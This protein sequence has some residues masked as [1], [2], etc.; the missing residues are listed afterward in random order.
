VSKKE[1]AIDWEKCKGLLLEGTRSA[2]TDFM[3]KTPRSELCAIGY[4]FELGNESPQFDLCADTWSNRKRSPD[5]ELPDARW[6][7]GNYEFP[8]GLSSYSELGSE[9]N[10]VAGLLH[11]TAE[12]E[13]YFDAVYKG[14]VRIG[15]EVLVELARGGFLGDWQLLDFNVSEVGD[16]IEVVSARNAKIKKLIESD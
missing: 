5:W 11:N 13:R 9:W 16:S 12:K 10:D 6:N 8:A 3:K 2:I 7:S 14:L 4:V 15:C 1:A